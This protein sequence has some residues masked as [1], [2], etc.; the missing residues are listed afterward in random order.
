MRA[1]ASAMQAYDRPRQ[2]DGQMFRRQPTRGEMRKIRAVAL[3]ELDRAVAA[4]EDAGWQDPAFR[5]IRARLRHEAGLAGSGTERTQL[6]NGAAT[7]WTVLR[8]W[9]QD[10]D[11]AMADWERALVFLL[12]AATAVAGAADGQGDAEAWLATGRQYLEAVAAAEFGDGPVHQDIKTWR[13]VAAAIDADGP[14][15]ELPGIDFVTVE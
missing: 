5:Y 10:G 12:S 13:K 11:V 14:D 4:A 9:A 7:D 6:L 1:Y 2:P 8:G 15:A 3:A